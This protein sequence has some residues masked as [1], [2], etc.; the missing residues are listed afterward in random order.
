MNETVKVPKTELDELKEMHL[1]L[2]TKIKEMD[3]TYGKSSILTETPK[4]TETKKANKS[5]KKQL[6]RGL[7][8]LEEQVEEMEEL[9][10]KID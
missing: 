10:S 3:G 5:L 9:V 6:T 2:E 4:S 1:Q 7:V 8:E